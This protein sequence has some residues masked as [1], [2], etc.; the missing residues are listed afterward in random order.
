MK[1]SSRIVSIDVFRGMTIALMIIVNTPGSW[2]YVYPPF[3]HAHWHGWTPT[4]LV[5]PFFLFIMGVSMAF[6]FAKY[7][8]RISPSFTK[9]VL[10]RSAVILLIGWAL[11]AF[12]F[13]GFDIET[14]RWMG[15]LPRIAWVYLLASFAVALFSRRNLLIIGLLILAVYWWS[16]WYWGGQDPFSLE[17]NLPRRIDLAVL[18]EKHLWRGLG[19][20][21]DPEGIWSTF[22]A[23]VTTI[24]GFLYGY[25]MKVQKVTVPFLRASTA[26]GLA[27][28]A[29]AYLV[30]FFFPIN[31][32]LW[33]SSYVL[34][35]TG[36]GIVILAG[37]AYLLDIINWKRGNYFF[38]VF[39]RNA[40]MGFVLSIFFV[41]IMLYVWKYTKADGTIE[42][43]YH[44][45]FTRVFQP[46]LGNY[47]GSFAF[48]LVYMLLIWAILF[49]MDRKGIYVKI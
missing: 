11:R 19:I 12:P 46:L 9:K 48:A 39:G 7:D 24:S 6:S 3:R 38:L 4:D 29:L 23:V 43:G 31:K 1:V 40:L 2:S 42:N 10:R 36:L 8:Y 14:F 34:L 45:L 20:A 35:T 22:P 28:V 47:P 13:T 49:A 5:F 25:Q 18:G 32:S 17:A 33:S 26:L 21:F 16:L 44:W 27:I 41:K 37:L 30:D 15:V